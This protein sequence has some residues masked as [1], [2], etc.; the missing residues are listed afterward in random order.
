M[1]CKRAWSQ[2]LDLKAATAQLQAAEEARKA[3]SAE[4]L[5]SASLNGTYGIQG[6]NPNQGVPVFQAA[7]S[8]QSANIPGRQDRSRHRA[9][10]GG[11]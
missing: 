9:S 8:V 6:V 5:P 1:L 7:I 11:P 4:R 2:R 3:A 10:G